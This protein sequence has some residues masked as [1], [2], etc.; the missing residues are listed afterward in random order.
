[1]VKQID[2]LPKQL[3]TQQASRSA[4]F[5]KA[6]CA[7]ARPA[8]IIFWSRRFAL[9]LRDRK[10]ANILQ[11]P[12]ISSPPAI[13]AAWPDRER[14]FDPGAPHDRTSRLAYG[15]D[16]TPRTRLSSVN[17]QACFSFPGQRLRKQ[18]RV[19]KRRPAECCNKSA[20][21]GQIIR[22]EPGRE[23]VR[24]LRKKASPAASDDTGTFP[25]T[26]CAWR[27]PVNSHRLRREF[28]HRARRHVWSAARYRS[29]SAR[30]RVKTVRRAR[31]FA[32]RQSQRVNH[33]IPRDRSRSRN[34]SSALR[35]PQNRIQHYAR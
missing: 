1:M 4:I 6:I 31:K 29:R 32:A 3:L 25:K 15:G 12:R 20:V 22:A 9:R 23:R 34:A 8:P 7:A 33:A 19:P 14:N 21:T 18:I 5:P 17:P 35:K 30:K 16:K 24:S 11:P 10:I 27:P 28:R 26:R 2:A 13:S